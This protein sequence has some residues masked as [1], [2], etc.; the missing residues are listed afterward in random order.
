MMEVVVKSP[1]INQCLVTYIKSEAIL[2]MECKKHDYSK[3]LHR[4]YLLFQEA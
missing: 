2:V 1:F 4:E 3:M